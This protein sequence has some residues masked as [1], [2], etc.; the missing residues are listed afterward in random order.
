MITPKISLPVGFRFY[1]PDPVMRQW[2]KNDEKLK[3]QGI[4]KSERPVEPAKNSKYPSKLALMLELLEEFKF[5][6]LHIR[7][8]AIMGDALYGSAWFMNQ[9][10][11]VFTDTQTISQLQ[12][13]QIVQ[14]RNRE[15]SVAQ[16]FGKYHGYVAK[17]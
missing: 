16:Y 17:K 2:K 14:Y 10:T 6:H 11:K 9:A 3:K 13:S 8:K 15:M 1:E 4:K 7:V 12:K 5:Y